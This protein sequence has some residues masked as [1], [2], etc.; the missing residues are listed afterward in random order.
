MAEHESSPIELVRRYRELV[1]SYEALDAKIDELIMAT[2]GG[3]DKMSDADLG[4]YRDWARE[5][6]EL[7]NNMRV[8]ERQLNLTVDDAPGVD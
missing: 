4:R 8:L 6:T 5:R 1:E 2:K 3:R 7:L